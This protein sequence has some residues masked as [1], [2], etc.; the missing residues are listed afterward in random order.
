MPRGAGSGAVAP[1]WAKARISGGEFDLG[2]I[3][4]LSSYPKSGNTW[5][6]AYLANLFRNPEKPVPINELPNFALGDNFLVHYEKFSGKKA[7]D[8]SPE[9]ITK[10]RPRVHEWFATFQPD[11]VLVKTHNACVIADGQPLITPSATAGAIYVVRNPLD[12]ALS[13]ANHYQM[14]TQM[15]VELICD[16]RHA[17]PPIEGQIEQVLLSWS[18]HVKS[19]TRTPFKRLHVM[20][21]E[22]MRAKPFKTFS[23]LSKFL[24]LPQ[25]PERIKKA[26][27]F[28]SFR[29]L[30][31]QEQKGGFV[32]A[33]PDG[34]AK[35]FHAGKAGGWRK[36]L[37]EDQ[38]A[39]VVEVHRE[40]M[41]EFGYLSAN[42]EPC[43]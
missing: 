5:L 31:S 10:L 4:W 29:E 20:R 1:G 27:R 6:R 37:T 12:V 40:V 39:Q 41:R 32:E 33:R 25:E 22:D 30:R 14:T 7:E 17:L 8:L 23:A 21:Y 13:L 18:S 34:K 36:V 9:E 24:G 43:T 42:D 15:T 26:I 11:T 2:G 35:F 19:W 16:E 3:L 28:S 38:V